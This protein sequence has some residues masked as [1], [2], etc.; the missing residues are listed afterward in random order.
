M[1][2]PIKNTAECEIRG[3]KAADFHRQICEVYGEHIMSNGML[4]KLVRAYKNGCT[5]AR[6]EERSGIHSLI[7]DNLVLTIVK[8]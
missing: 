2:P 6:D 3:L 4:R 5:N 7:T 8:K 1:T